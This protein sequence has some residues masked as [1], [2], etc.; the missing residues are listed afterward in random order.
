MRPLFSVLQPLVEG[1]LC[2]RPGDAGAGRGPEDRHGG[3]DF[4]RGRR[5]ASLLPAAVGECPPGG[6]TRVQGGNRDQRL[7]V[8]AR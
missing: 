5:T 6:G 7:N 3:M 1:D 4:L 2:H 8:E